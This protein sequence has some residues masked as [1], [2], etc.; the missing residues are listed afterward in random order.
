MPGTTKL[1]RVSYPAE[2][3]VSNWP[4]LPAATTGPAKSTRI[5]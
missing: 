5:D 2:Q 4:E 1:V 3:H